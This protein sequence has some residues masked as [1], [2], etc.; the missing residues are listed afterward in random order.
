MTVQAFAA[1]LSEIVGSR[2]VHAPPAEIEL[3]PEDTDEGAGGY[4]GDA[5]GQSFMIEYV[6]ARGQRSRRRI[7][8]WSIVGGKDGVPCLFA[9]CHE[10]NANR[11]FRIDRIACCIDY[12]GE[13]FDDVPAFLA[14]NFGMSAGLA[15]SQAGAAET[16]WADIRNRIW[17]D[18]VLLSAMCRADMTV[19]S[20]EVEAATAHLSA[21]AERQGAMLADGE[22]EAIA[23]YTARLRPGIEAVSRALAQVSSRQP[24]DIRRTLLAAVRVMDCDGQRHPAEANLL[25]ALSHELLGIR[26]FR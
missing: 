7:T 20:V 5:E 18:A 23:R 22:I 17:A 14:E 3:P 9:R 2:P 21:V 11:T 8:V 4:L 10:R 19:R 25:N 6:D 15:R 12:G 24:D 1:S 26:L 13:V 16:R